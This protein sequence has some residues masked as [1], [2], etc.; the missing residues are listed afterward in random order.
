MPRPSLDWVGR[1]WET[2]GSPRLG[3]PA[4]KFAAVI[5][6]GDH[7][8]GMRDARLVGLRVLL[9]DREQHAKAM[10]AKAICGT[11]H[12]GDVAL[13]SPVQ[14]QF[15][16]QEAHESSAQVLKM[17]STR[18]ADSIGGNSRRAKRCWEEASAE[19]DHEPEGPEAR[20]WWRD[21][22]RAA[23]AI[24]PGP[25]SDRQC[26]FPGEGTMTIGPMATNGDGYF[27]RKE[28][29]SILGPHAPL[30]PDCKC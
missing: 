23:D 14:Q 29:G 25:L 7:P 13:L 15:E 27:V 26:S 1:F 4:G 9:F 21:V 17:L 22:P 19:E 11:I 2:T 30:M 8:D 5:R 18:D 10:A 20:S 12:G 28:D 16:K 3:V 24:Q 6:A